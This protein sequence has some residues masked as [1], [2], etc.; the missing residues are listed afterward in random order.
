V[1]KYIHHSGI[2]TVL[3]LASAML[4]F[5]L[6]QSCDKTDTTPT[7]FNAYLPLSLGSFN[8]YQVTEKVYTA[9]QKEPATTTWQEKDETDRIL[10]QD[11][12]STVY[13]I[14]RYKRNVATDYWQKTQE[15]TVTKYPDKVLTGT[16][17]QTIFSLVLPPDSKIRWN[18]NLYNNKDAQEFQY[19]AIN[20][21]D[22]VGKLTFDKTLTVVERRDTSI[23]NRYIGIKKYALGTGLIQ[24]EQTSYEYCQDDNCIGSGKIESGTYKIRKLIESGLLK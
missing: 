10:S 8:V 1:K 18:G 13:V 14:A 24:D 17:N 19:E 21:P 6:I 16:D 2:K 5:I 7:D 12:N 22:S 20:L 15:Y 3:R 4:A 23:I 11:A 9:S